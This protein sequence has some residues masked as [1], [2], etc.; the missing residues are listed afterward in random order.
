MK[1]TWIAVTALTTGVLVVATLATRRP[2]IVVA[3]PG[4]RVVSA[5]SKDQGLVF[6]LSEGV[7]GGGAYERAPVAAAQPL[8]E[9]ETRRL[10]DR[11]PPVAAQPADQV[12]FA[13]RESSLPAPR[14][15]ATVKEPFPP[16][17]RPSPPPTPVPAGRCR[18]C[19]SSPAATCRWP[20]TSA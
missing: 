15:G 17:H 8:G 13:L 16:P 4:G 11:L 12:D 18:C 1:R 2:S 10:L 7:E 5:E 3:S 19:G 9:A 6:R 14:A 20:R